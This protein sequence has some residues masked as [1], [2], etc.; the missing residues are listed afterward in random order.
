MTHLKFTLCDGG[1]GWEVGRGVLNSGDTWHWLCKECQLSFTMLGQ[2]P[3]HLSLSKRSELC[4]WTPAFYRCE[5]RSLKSNGHLVT[6]PGKHSGLLICHTARA[7]LSIFGKP[8]YICV[9]ALVTGIN[10]DFPGQTYNP[11]SHCQASILPA[12]REASVLA[13]IINKAT[14]LVK[15]AHWKFLFRYDNDECMSPKNVLATYK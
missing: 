10:Y 8:L 1:L 15:T 2:E 9:R 3:E 4:C 14:A 5:N 6:K 7:Q 13:S 12:I 11:I